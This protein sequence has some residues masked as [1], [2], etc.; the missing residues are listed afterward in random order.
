MITIVCTTFQQGMPV[1]GRW[2]RFYT[3]VM[4]NKVFTERQ[5]TDILLYLESWENHSALWSFKKI[6]FLAGSE[7][8]AL[9]IKELVLSGYYFKS[10]L[11][12]FISIG[13]IWIRNKG[14][15]LESA[16]C[17]CSM[18][19]ERPVTPANLKFA[20]LLNSSGPQF[21]AACEGDK[22]VCFT[23]EFKLESWYQCLLWTMVQ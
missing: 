21:T 1:G 3:L 10:L 22:S 20:Y 23:Y 6:C 12:A 9:F 7:V 11:N 15:L 16:C 14:R 18:R 17:A 5:R 19:E 13:R 2:S 4:V 8:A